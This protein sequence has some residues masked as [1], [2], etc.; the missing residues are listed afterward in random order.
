MSSETA[1]RTTMIET[2]EKVVTA[3]KGTAFQGEE[4]RE[5]RPALNERHEPEEPSRPIWLTQFL[6]DLRFGVRILAS[7]RGFAVVALLTLALG[8]GANTAIFS[9]LYGV[10]LKPLPY[11]HPESIVRVWQATRTTA[12]NKLGM[13]EGQFVALRQQMRSFSSLGAYTVGFSTVAGPEQSER[14]ITANLSSDV[15]PSFGVQPVLGHGFRKEDE[16]E[17]AAPSAVLSYEFWQRRFGGNRN[18]IGQALKIDGKLVTVA[19]VL[20]HSFFLPEDFVGTETVQIYLPLKINAA[21]PNWSTWDLLPVARLKEGASEQSATAEVGTLFRRLWQEHPIGNN[22]LQELDWSLRTMPVH[23]D[24]VGDVSVGL[25]ILAAAVGVVLAIVCA[26][27]AGLL[28]ARAA[29][30]Q[31]EISIRSAVGAQPMRIIRQLLTESLVLS[32]G[33]AIL[34]LGLAYGAVKL[35]LG[36]GGANI[37]RLG[38]VGL[39]IPVLLFAL[40]SCVV[41]SILFG[42]VPALQ[43]AR[44]DLNKCLRDEGRGASA[45]ASKSRI[46]RILVV[47]EVSSAV[48]LVI[49]AGLLLRSVDHLLRVDPGFNPNNVLMAR[50]TLPPERYKDGGVVNNFSNDL[51]TR[52]RGLPGVTSAAITSAPPLSG[53]N[54]GTIFGI[55]GRSTELN[56]RQRVG[57]VRTTPDYFKTMGISLTRGRAIEESDSATTNPVVVI[58]EALAHQYF[59]TEDPLGK[60]IRLYSTVSQAGPWAEI[61]G[62]TKNVTMRELN[63]QPEPQVY[64]PMAQ[65]QQIIPWAFRTTLVVHSSSDPA[66]LSGAIRKQASSLDSEAPV[67]EFITGKQAVGQTISQPH[68]D[69]ILLGLFAM[70]ALV[71]ASVGVYGILANVV[72]QRTREIG[73][74]I[75]LGASRAGVFRMVIG[76]GMKLALTGVVIGVAGALIATR[77]LSSL[78]VAVRPSDPVTFTVVAAIFVAIAF[79]A[80][81]VPAY[82]AMRVDPMITLRYE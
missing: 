54:L 2:E 44:P 62:V 49:G 45:G 41:S 21:S 51:L 37:P 48:I 69:L 29:T 73:I 18:A 75:A 14:I 81:Y 36:L 20:P 61:V 24:I 74:R 19:G 11:A 68:F 7:S 15:L 12:N 31:K 57:L 80:C 60:H 1:G 46:Y 55:E 9:V 56:M 4:T 28:L 16:T 8:I 72:R 71:L 76:Q 3:K 38:D 50:I 33:G 32:L 6:Q 26:N 43:A 47:A 27:V 23:E 22:T 40:G 59:N 34:G 30:R 79:V 35:I 67:S 70:V 77:L 39:N 5:K 52:V 13:N 25:W 63:E 58:N 17:G 78:L 65:G 66:I 82:R 10:L 53:G 42:L 64:F